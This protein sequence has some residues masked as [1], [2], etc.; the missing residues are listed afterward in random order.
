M[1]KI[2]V[3]IFLI[4]GSFYQGFAQET[5]EKD[6]TKKDKKKTPLPLNSGR[7][8]D[9]DLSE[10]SWMSLDVGPDGSIVFDFLGDIYTLPS[11]GGDATQIT[12]G[13]AFDSQPRYS[14]DGK[15]IVYI[16]DE[17]GGDNVWIY[18]FDSEEKKQITIIK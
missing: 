11:T 3:F 2:A 8:F 7:T 1:N 4:I 15:K 16:S 9:F 14:P 5:T 10:G 13:L 18:D 17:S 12:K 6:S